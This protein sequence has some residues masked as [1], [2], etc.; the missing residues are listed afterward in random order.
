MDLKL[1]W[2]LFVIVFFAIVTAY[3]FIIGRK[4]TLK[5]IIGTYIATLTADGIGNV[6]QNLVGQTSFFDKLVKFIGYGG[7]AANFSSI[8]K[9]V[10]FIVIIV[11]LTIY[12]DF[13]IHDPPVGQNGFI[14]LVVLILLS[15][16]SCGLILSTIIVFANGG[17]L[18]G[19]VSA[20]SDSFREVY[21]QSRLVKGLLDWH[22]AWFSLPGLVFVITSLFQKNA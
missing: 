21:E 8:L 22:D 7:G 12:G 16:L 1:S 9:I 14:G 6:F 13:E 2:D 19:G 11:I 20:I 10:L 4:D 17:S 5:I 18:I 15:I 3:S